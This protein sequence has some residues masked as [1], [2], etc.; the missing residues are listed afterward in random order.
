MDKTGVIH[1]RFQVLHKDH[2]KYLLE[3]KKRCEHLIIGICRPEQDGSGDQKSHRTKQSANPLTYY[4]RAVCI[5]EA[6]VEAGVRREEFDIVP[7]P[8][9]TPEKLFNYVPMDAVFYLTI[10]DTWGEEK[11]RVLTEQLHVKT[12]VMWKVPLEEK[13]I[14]ATDVRELICRGEDWKDQVPE[15][16]YR[17]LTEQKIDQRIQS[18]CFQG[19]CEQR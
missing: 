19:S 13:G 11:Y 7:F 3:A 1:G 14:S 8:I 4:E 12:E 18:C 5:R 9:D 17:Y 10:Y 16:V 2:L 6:M 15:S